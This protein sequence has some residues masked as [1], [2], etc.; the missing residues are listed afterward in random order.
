MS[1]RSRT[2]RLR[3]TLVG[4]QAK[5]FAEQSEQARELCGVQRLT[6]QQRDALI[7]LALNTYTAPEGVLQSL[8]LMPMSRH[9][10]ESGLEIKTANATT[11][12][13]TEPSISDPRL[14]ASDN[15]SACGTCGNGQEL[16]PGHMGFVRLPSPI[17]NPVYID[18]LIAV[19]NSVCLACG[20]A[21]MSRETITQRGIENLKTLK[22]LKEIGKAAAGIVICQNCRMRVRKY[23]FDPDNI[24]ILDE[25]DNTAFSMKSIYETLQRLP[26]DVN[27]LLGFENNTEP[28]DF[29][30]FSIPIIPPVQR[31]T[32]K[33]GDMYRVDPITTAYQNLLK[34]IF[35]WTA[36]VKKTNI[37]DTDLNNIRAKIKSIYNRYKDMIF[38]KSSNV[39]VKISDVHGSIND[40]LGTKE[41][42]IRMNTIAK[43]TNQNARTVAGPEPNIRFGEI[44]VPRILA[45]KLT[46]PV[47]I[48]TDQLLEFGQKLYQAGKVDTIQRGLYTYYITDENRS[49]Y[50]VQIGDII[51]RH[52]M[53]G[54]YVVMNRQP[55]LTMYSMMGYKAVIYDGLTIRIPL[56][57]CKPHNADFDGDEL[58]INVPQDE[59]AIREVAEEMSVVKNLLSRH[60]NNI[61]AAPVMNAKTGLYILTSLNSW[62]DFDDFLSYNMMITRPKNIFKFLAKFNREII[63]A[64]LDSSNFFRSIEHS[65]NVESLN[66]MSESEDVY[67]RDF[68]NQL[69]SCRNK[70]DN[71]PD[72]SQVFGLVVFSLIL[73]DNF[74]YRPD[75]NI[76]IHKGLLL[77]CSKITKYIGDSSNSIGHMIAL[78]YGT[79]RGA[80]FITD[81][82]WLGEE[83]IQR[84][85]FSI[86]AS[87]CFMDNLDIQRTTSEIIND[88]RRF[89]VD[90]YDRVL[91]TTIDKME[92]QNQ[93]QIKTNVLG[94]LGERIMPHI[95]ADNSLVVMANAGA[96]GGAN[97]VVQVICAVGQQYQNAEIAQPTLSNGLRML[98]TRSIF[99]NTADAHGFCINSFGK[100]LSVEEVFCHAMATRDSLMGTALITQQIG[101]LKRRIEQSLRNAINRYNNTLTS[102]DLI[103]Q[104]ITGNN[105]FDPK[106]LKKITI[107]KEEFFTPVDVLHEMEMLNAED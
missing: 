99:D 8:L 100:G 89:V 84:R 4:S 51:H 34:D 39:G 3:S 106:Y 6:H 45:D 87:D 41:G 79:E 33:V 88:V 58:N 38:K 31:P 97:N 42:A 76:N 44:A 73:P 46:Q 68:A 94:K 40:R 21:L 26:S 9:D 61:I 22:R 10:I 24:E 57:A 98:P 13:I 50:N 47:A 17:P 2:L 19:L 104:Y 20:A 71:I 92:R 52:L 32:I 14:G 107:Q 18:Y 1:S 105:I 103:I 5:Q 53:D 77:K 59:E 93:I 90:A 102:F 55:T 85:G 75:G 65:F 7:G 48:N 12:N 96:K 70:E 35:D 101:F 43:R 36:L 63:E 60:M 15:V 54:D 23:K 37:T 29:I 72:K 56:P 64:G 86:G 83:Y 16:C 11:I 49:K 67:V 66:I 95:P 62:V 82:T 27:K 25:E 69:I 28:K 78:Y 30:M 80:D 74:E 91:T 81:A